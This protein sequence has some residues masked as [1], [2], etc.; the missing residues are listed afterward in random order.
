MF[1]SLIQSFKGTVGKKNLKYLEE[2]KKII[3]EKLYIKS[4]RA[5][6]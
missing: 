2:E 3:L 4:Q 1:S 6:M 5:E